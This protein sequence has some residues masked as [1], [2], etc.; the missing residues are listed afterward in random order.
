MLFVIGIVSA[1]TGSLFNGPNTT[2]SVQIFKNASSPLRAAQHRAWA[3]ALT[4]IV[5]VFLFTVLA[6]IVHRD[7]LTPFDGGLTSEPT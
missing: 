5:I 1:R 7:L 3:A 4:L 6:R 2:L